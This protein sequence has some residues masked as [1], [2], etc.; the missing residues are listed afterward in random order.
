MRISGIVLSPNDRLV[1]ALTKV[2]GIGWTTSKKILLDLKI[3]E[4]KRVND[5]S[6]EMSQEL[7]QVV[8]KQYKIEGILR[9]SINDDLKRL[10]DINSYVGLR[11]IMN[12]PVHGQRTRSN[13]RTKRGQRKTVGSFTKEAWA[14]MEQMQK[15][16]K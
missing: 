13:A 11:H 8:E 6:E 10:K 16:K 15:A 5:L 2:Y 3:S 4:E 7:V 9:E 12:L 14:K 1:Y